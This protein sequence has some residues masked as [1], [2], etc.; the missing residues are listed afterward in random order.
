MRLARGITEKQF[1]AGLLFCE[2]LGKVDQHPS[3]GWIADFPEGNDE[4]QS[5]DNVQVDFIVAKQLQQLVS[6]GI[7]IVDI[8]RKHSGIPKKMAS[9]KN[10]WTNSPA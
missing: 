9:P 10:F 1:R 6:A 4:P 3:I 5:F 2:T 8:Q 7:G